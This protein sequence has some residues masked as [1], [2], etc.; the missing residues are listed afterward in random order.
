MSITD[1]TTQLSSPAPL[2]SQCQTTTTSPLIPPQPPRRHASTSDPFG[3][4][5][6]E[7]ELQRIR[8]PRAVQA[9]YLEPLRHKPNDA[10]PRTCELQLRSYNVRNLEVFA[11]FA[12]RAAYYLKL[13]ALGPIPLPKITERWTVPRSNFV[14][15]KSQENYE[16]I[17]R[18]GRSKYQYYGVG[19]KANVFDSSDLDVP[20][21]LDA[22]AEDI[23]KKLAE[24][25]EGLPNLPPCLE[26]YPGQREARKRELE[27][28]VL[29][30]PF[31]QSWGGYAALGPADYES[32]GQRF[33]RVRV[34]GPSVA[35]GLQAEREEERARA[36]GREDV[37]EGAGEDVSEGEGGK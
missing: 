21:S 16:R 35:M 23:G 26:K 31:K 10:D 1:R 6:A 12:M 36:Q 11:D 29:D 24:A 13:S 28:R 34:N 25:A 14:H 30:E 2:A 32:R 22:I 17:T 18:R 5:D 37:K 3:D 20:E 19:M 9:T 15:K 7:A 8:L 33:E 4:L 27:A